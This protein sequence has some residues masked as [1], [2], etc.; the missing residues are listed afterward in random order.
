MR[1]VRLLRAQMKDEMWVKNGI[2]IMHVIPLSY[3]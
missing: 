1:I 3:I 2:K